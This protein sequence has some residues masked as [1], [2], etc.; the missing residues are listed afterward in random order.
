M[1][2]ELKKA[3]E[4]N[5]KNASKESVKAYDALQYTQAALNAA[6][7]LRCIKD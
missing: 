3:I 1:K 7:A 6:N 2:E 5:A 4:V